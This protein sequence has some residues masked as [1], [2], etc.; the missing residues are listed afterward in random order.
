MDEEQLVRAIWFASSLFVGSTFWQTLFQHPGLVVDGC[1]PARARGFTMFSIFSIH[2]SSSIP[3]L[4]SSIF[5][6]SGFASF[7]EKSKQLTLDT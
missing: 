6:D 3:F 2:L 1:F 5:H 7:W 4:S